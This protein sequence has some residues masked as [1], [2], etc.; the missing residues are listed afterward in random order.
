MSC[1]RYLFQSLLPH[2][3]NRSTDFQFG[4]LGGLKFLGQELGRNFF[5]RVENSR[6]KEEHS[7]R[8]FEEFMDA[9]QDVSSSY[10]VISNETYMKMV[11]V[12]NSKAKA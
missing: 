9:F 2:A 10:A 5:P 6:R 12:T 7:S 11:T 1:P 3:I 4:V 8:I